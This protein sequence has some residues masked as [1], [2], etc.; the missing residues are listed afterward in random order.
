MGVY[1]EVH[2]TRAP[3]IFGQLFVTVVTFSIGS[4]ISLVLRNKIAWVCLL[5]TRS[6]W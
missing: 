5:L 6:S 3:A 4:A 2:N 1:R